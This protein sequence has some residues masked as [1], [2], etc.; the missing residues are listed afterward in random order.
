[1]HRY[2]YSTDTDTQYIYGTKNFMG[3]G[4]IRGKKC[5]KVLLRKTII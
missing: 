1:M 2:P 3:E 5:L 4:V